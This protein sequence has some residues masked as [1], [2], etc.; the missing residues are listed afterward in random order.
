MHVPHGGA[1]A[2]AWPLSAEGLGLGLGL[3]RSGWSLRKGIR[4]RAASAPVPRWLSRSCSVCRPPPTLPIREGLD[5]SHHS[6][7]SKLPGQGLV[8][9]KIKGANSGEA[10]ASTEASLSPPTGM[11]LI[12]LRA[13]IPKPTTLKERSLCG[14]M[15]KRVED[16]QEAQWQEGRTH[17]DSRARSSS[18]GGSQ[19]RSSSIYNDTNNKS[20]PCQADPKYSA[21]I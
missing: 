18:G 1:Q 21:H 19:W 16:A 12:M 10:E 9:K 11:L 2:Q 15:G 6:R 3:G 8:E 14:G 4:G 13:Q 7:F 5:S 20:A 17:Q